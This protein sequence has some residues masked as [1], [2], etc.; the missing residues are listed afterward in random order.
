MHTARRAV[1]LRVR[2]PFEHHHP[3]RDHVVC[4]VVEIAHAQRVCGHRD[5][6]DRLSI[7]V[8][9][10]EARR[11]RQIGRQVPHGALNGRLHF[12]LCLAH[13]FVEDEL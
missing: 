7:R 1:H 2:D 12:G 13:V 11:L 3:L 6:D 9:C 8:R 4:I 10:L 5:V